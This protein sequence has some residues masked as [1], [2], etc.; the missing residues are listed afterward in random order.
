MGH[1]SGQRRM[2]LA[3]ILY[4]E[5]AITSDLVARSA[6]PRPAIT[7]SGL[8]LYGVSHEALLVPARSRHDPFGAGHARVDSSV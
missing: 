2:I 4:K 8:S 5:R 6:L 3:P 7:A 1:N